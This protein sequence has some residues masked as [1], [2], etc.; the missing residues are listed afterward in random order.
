MFAN[1][2][3]CANPLC[4][5]MVPEGTLYCCG[6]CI[7]AHERNYEIH[8]DGVLAH[9]DGCNER[10]KARREAYPYLYKK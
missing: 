2:V 3:K 10:D 8:E 1:L 5:R 4:D 7:Y 6:S 9:A